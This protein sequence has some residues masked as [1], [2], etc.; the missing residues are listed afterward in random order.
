MDID[1]LIWFAQSDHMTDM[2][3]WPKVLPRKGK[4]VGGAALTDQLH[5][6]IYC[7]GTLNVT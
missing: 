3:A 7:N 2:N 1:G 5:R 4:D 6:K